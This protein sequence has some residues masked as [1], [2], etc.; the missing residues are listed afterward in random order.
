[1]GRDWLSRSLYGARISLSV[2]LVAVG[3]SVTIGSVVGAVAGYYGGVV[4]TVICRIID[5]LMCVPTFFLI[6]TVNAFLK[7]SIFNV[8]VIIGIFGWMGTARLVR[9][10]IL[11]IREQEFVEASVALGLSDW[12]I[13]TKD[14]LPNVFA[15]LIVTA[16]TGIAGAIMTESA[17]SYLGMG[18]QEPFPSWGAMLKSAQDHLLTAPWLA[19]FPGILISIT[20]CLLYTSRIACL[21]K[22]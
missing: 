18:V 4:D 19:I 6:L 17:L 5:V 22:T 15:Q 7:P 2:G 10:Q 9:G 3:I 12:S 8:M 21:S 14:V 1:M 20:V 13:I 16:T 11:S